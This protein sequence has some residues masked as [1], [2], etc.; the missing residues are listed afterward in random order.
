MT[1][2]HSAS[3]NFTLSRDKVIT[4]A[5]LAGCCAFLSIIEY[6]IPKP[7]PFMRLGIANIP[8]MISLVI[9]PAKLSF[10]LVLLKI[11]SQGI[12]TGTLFSY[13]FIFSFC[14]SL[15]GG[16]AMIFSKKL[17]GKNISMIGVSITGALFSNA[18]QLLA[19]RFIIFGQ[20]AIV[21]APPVIV[22]G[23]ITS[24]ITGVIAQTFIVKS[25]W[26]ASHRGVLP[27]D[28]D[29][30]TADSSLEKVSSPKKKP[31][32]SIQ[33]KILFFTAIIIL[34]AFLFTNSIV[35][36]GIF[37]ATAV[38]IAIITGKRFRLLPNLIISFCV[39]AANL[40]P[41]GGYILAKIGPFFI[42][43]EA[44]ITGIN[45]SLLL[46]GSAYISRFAIGKELVFPGKGGELLY[47]TFFYFEKFTEIRL[48]FKK[49]LISQ[50]DSL[51]ISL[52]KTVPE[53]APDTLFSLELG[54]LR[55]ADI[56]FFV[57]TV[58]FYWLLFVLQL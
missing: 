43:V 56:I 36:R 4:L 11:A 40:Y 45:K 48:D 55:K 6:V 57:T 25:K 23:T 13:I 30:Q 41:P 33:P 26:I 5:L 18:V 10:A 24:I 46:I 22:I 21:I 19:A 42:T 54:T 49:N 7:L 51:I 15:A 27:D 12:I 8:I 3:D 31:I 44:L 37:T 53:A 1:L 17:F 38:L 52:E 58:I 35:F 29:T 14:G 28:K 2:I 39:I 9:F 50:I 34:P 32:L 47:K 20:A 16:A